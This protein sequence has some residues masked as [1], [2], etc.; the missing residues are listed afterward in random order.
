MTAA[1][2]YDVVIVG[3]GPAGSAAAIV[4]CQGGLRVALVDLPVT[5]TLKVGESLPGAV[6]RLLQRLGIHN[7]DALLTEDDYIPCLANASAWGTPHWSYKDA[8]ANPEGGGW[9][10]AR[11]QFDAAIRQIAVAAGAELLIGR[12][13]T[14]QTQCLDGYQINFHDENS[15]IDATVQGRWVIDASGRRGVVAR[16]LGGRYQRVQEQLAAVGWFYCSPDDHEQM[17]RVKTVNEG[18]WY[19]ARIPDG[20]RVAV[21]HGGAEPVATLA[22]DAESFTAAYQA[23]ELLP[24]GWES[25]QLVQKPFACDAGIKR[26]Q[27]AGAERW[28]AVGD[29]VLAF[30][31]LLAQGM[32]F[33]LYSGILGGETILKDTHAS[34]AD[35]AALISQ[36]SHKVSQVYTMNLGSMQRF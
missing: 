21:F 3:A 2:D 22:R 26:L 25:P 17:T 6:A 4:L 1:S 35:R 27:P 30:D 18:W 15:G 29:A 33:A 36:F 9:H 23:A 31:P 20:M 32:F 7:L 34:T 8:L 11:Q 19:T 10:I 5:D 13:N 28:L 14:V 24:F 16:Q 12:V